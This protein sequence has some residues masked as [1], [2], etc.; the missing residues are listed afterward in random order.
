MIDTIHEIVYANYSDG[1]FCLSQIADFL[2]LSVAYISKV[3]RNYT[4]DSL[5]SFINMVRVEKAAELLEK[6]DL[7]VNQIMNRIGI[8]NESNFYRNFKKHFGSTPKEY[9]LRIQMNK[10]MPG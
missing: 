10:S 7:S 1:N 5:S 6:T 9:A 2:K 8:D 3:Y 4:G